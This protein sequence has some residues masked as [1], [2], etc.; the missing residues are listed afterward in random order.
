[1]IFFK[2][3]FR[4]T[5]STSP[6]SCFVCS[7]VRCQPGEDDSEGGLPPASLAQSSSGATTAPRTRTMARGRRLP[8]PSFWVLMLR[9]HLTSAWTR[10][11]PWS[12]RRKPRTGGVRT[13]PGR[14]EQVLE[15]PASPAQMASTP[16]G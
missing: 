1:M 11:T 4:P 14:E 2:R 16:P 5:T 10:L 8:T 7:L 3:C 12:R 15:R 6:T 13:S 9:G